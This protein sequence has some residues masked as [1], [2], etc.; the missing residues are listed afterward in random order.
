LPKNV[1]GVFLFSFEEVSDGRK[2]EREERTRRAG[3]QERRG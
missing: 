3:D 1:L 2:K